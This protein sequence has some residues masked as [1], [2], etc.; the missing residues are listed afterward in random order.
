MPVR[1]AVRHQLVAAACGKHL[2]SDAPGVVAHE[3]GGPGA[4]SQAEAAIARVHD[5]QH[6]LGAEAFRDILDLGHRDRV[7][8]DLVG[9]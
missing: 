3:V 6:M 5:K 7:G 2:A 8:G 9:V 4:A 1:P